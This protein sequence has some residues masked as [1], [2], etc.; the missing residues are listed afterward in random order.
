MG[1]GG[2]Q[3]GKGVKVSD[4]YYSATDCFGRFK[5]YKDVKKRK[6]KDNNG[7]KEKYINLRRTQK[8]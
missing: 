8:V 4:S 5:N 7:S 2:F 3:N 1:L 6:E